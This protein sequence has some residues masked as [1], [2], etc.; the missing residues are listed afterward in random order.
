[1]VNK[2]ITE[3][4]QTTYNITFWSKVLPPYTRFAFPSLLY[5]E[6][7]SEVGTR[8]V[9][10]RYKEGTKEELLFFF[11]FSDIPK[12]QRI[13]HRHL[14]ITPPG[15]S[16]GGYKKWLHPLPRMATPFSANGYTIR[17][18]GCSPGKSRITE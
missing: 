14:P 5:E 13:F 15:T 3:K 8:R 11:S 10:R 12:K 2:F 16:C 17:D 7:N 18:K 1:M 9:R 4:R 6:Q